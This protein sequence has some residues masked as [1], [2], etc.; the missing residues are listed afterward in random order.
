MIQH[1]HDPS[2]TQ[3]DPS[4]YTQVDIDSLYDIVMCLCATL[5]IEDTTVKKKL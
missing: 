2:V 3:M 4:R 5:S 1:L